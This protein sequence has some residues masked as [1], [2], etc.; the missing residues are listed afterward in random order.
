MIKSYKFDNKAV[1]LKLHEQILAFFD[2]IEFE[3]G[4]FDDNFLD[5]D[6]LE[7][8]NSHFKILK[9]PCIDIYNTVRTWD[10]KNR[11]EFC[12]EIRE[13][14]NIEN[15]CEGNYIPRKITRAST[16]IYKLVRSIFLNLY[17]Q[18][19]DGNPFNRKYHTKLRT[20][21]DNFSRLNADITL[22]P[23]C[24]IGEL[25]KHQDLTRDQYDHYLPQAIYPLSAI[26]FKNLVPT[27]KECNS[28][29][30]KGEK[31]I[32]AVS[33]NNKLF[34]PYALNHKGITID[35]KIGIDDKILENIT[36]VIT[37]QNPEHKN[38]QISSWKT[39]YAI[40]SRYQGFIQG[41]IEKWYR[42][43]WEYMNKSSLSG[44]TE[45]V[46][47]L[48]YDAFLELDEENYLNF[49]RRPALNSFLA[50]SLMAQAA[51]EA[52]YYST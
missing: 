26:N 49:I 8:A 51:I 45:S 12:L 47:I 30:A 32:I 46:K 48:T 37:F 28:F 27:C 29:D 18:V 17:K 39:I 15:I 38:A 44:L 9:Q 40:D 10:Q 11:S 50:G 24:G 43:F 36:W 22:C 20:H 41:R 21:F 5:P 25:K 52:T 34:F 6:L 13:S 23:I 19:L 14:N 42:H 35:L 16:G 2:R 31:D 3:T 7:I 4:L 1:Q 33:T